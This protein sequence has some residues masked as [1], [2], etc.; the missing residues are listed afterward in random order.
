MTNASE[1]RA[2]HYDEV[3]FKAADGTALYLRSVEPDEPKAIVLFLHGYADHGGRY[4]HVLEALAGAGYSAHALDYRGHG[5]AGGR[6]GFVWHFDDYLEDARAGVKQ[7]RLRHPTLPMFLF[8]HSHGGLITAMLMSHR[9]GPDVA[10]VVLSGP[11][12]KLKLEPSVVQLVQAH[13]VGR[14]IPILSIANPLTSDQ[15]TKDPAMRADSDADPLKHKVVTPRWFS[16]SNSAQSVVRRFASQFRTPVLIMHG[17]EDPIADP[18]GSKAFFEAIGSVDKTLTTY[19]GML[20]EV[21]HEVERHKPIG[22]A[23]AWMNARL[24]ARR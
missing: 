12:L 3:A 21:L 19:P 4:M 8:A 7:L 22:E 17:E 20:H 23:I 5:K 11:Y 15:L 16:Q 2:H 1:S 6:R 14:L 18:A 9:G 24:E 13:V 10:G